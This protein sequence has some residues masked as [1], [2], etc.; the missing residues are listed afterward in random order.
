M[1][2]HVLFLQGP[3]P[4]LSPLEAASQVIAG[5]CKS[6]KDVR[7]NLFFISL[8]STYLPKFISKPI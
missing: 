2:S 7:D 1:V 4:D 6:K 5:N 8:Q 3:Y